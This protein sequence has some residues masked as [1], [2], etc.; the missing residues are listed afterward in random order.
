MVVGLTL[1]RRSDSLFL[2]LLMEQETLMYLDVLLAKLI[3][4]NRDLN[5][6]IR[7]FFSTD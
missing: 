6:S 2:N 4:T 7:I 5:L 1:E 3:L